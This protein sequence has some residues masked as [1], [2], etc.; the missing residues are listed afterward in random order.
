LSGARSGLRLLL[1]LRRRLRRSRPW[2]SGGRR[3]WRRRRPCCLSRRSGLSFFVVFSDIVERKEK[4][5]ERSFAAS[6]P[7]L[8]PSL[9]RKATFAH[10]RSFSSNFS[11]RQCAPFRSSPR[12]TRITTRGGRPGAPYPAGGGP[13]ERLELPR[14]RRR[15]GTLEKLMMLLLQVLLF[16]RFGRRRRDRVV[17]VPLRFRSRRSGRVRPQ[18]PRHG[19]QAGHE[20]LV[21]QG[22]EQELVE[23]GHAARAWRRRGR[24]SFSSSSSSTRANRLLLLSFAALPLS[25]LPDTPSSTEGT[26]FR[27]CARAQERR[28]TERQI[29]RGG[30]RKRRRASRKKK[31][32]KKENESRRFVAFGPRPLPLPFFFKELF[33]FFS[34][35]RLFFSVVTLWLNSG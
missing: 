8:S 3:A 33:L 17:E 18:L 30:A 19:R 6:M 7:P 12:L 32:G 31:K 5:V 2:W 4:K 10:H 34:V 1:L 27:T 9:G 16:E 23:V 14:L 11:R 20:G 26:R 15:V 24:H 28:A 29:G 25:Q 13:L 35:S 21:V 22:L